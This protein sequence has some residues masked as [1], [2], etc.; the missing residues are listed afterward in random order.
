MIPFLE[1]AASAADLVGRRVRI[2]RNLRRHCYSVQLGGK[3]VAHCRRV[4]VRDAVFKVSE[5]GRQRVLRES[6]KNVHAWVIGTIT[7]RQVAGGFLPEQVFYNPF[8]YSTFVHEGRDHPKPIAS[9]ALVSLSERGTYA[10]LNHSLAK[11]VVDA[12]R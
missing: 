7:R 10:M 12:C 11:V 8:L 2:Y 3:V 6:R 5:A 1:D 4:F 9:A